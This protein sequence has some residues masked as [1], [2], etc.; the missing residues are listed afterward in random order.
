MESYIKQLIEDLKAAQNLSVPP[1]RH[2]DSEEMPLTSMEHFSGLEKMCFPPVEKLS[3]TQLQDLVDAIIALLEENK[4][5]V[6]VPARLLIELT[7]QKLL[8]KWTD[9]IDYVNSGLHG[10]DFCPENM[11]D[12]DLHE[13]CDWCFEVGADTIPVY[14]GI[15][16]DNGNKIDILDIP[17]PD[18]CLSCESFLDDDWEENV[19]C[20][21]T[22][23]EKREEGEEF[24][25][26]AW[27]RKT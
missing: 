2:D 23:A 7:Y 16:D 21:L 27:R 10:L 12:C 14:N 17:V 26:Y 3:H 18:L 9:E 11:D 8:E 19:L 13:W 24:V 25:C 4:Y 15:Y 20:N 22:R 5:V 6:N 1:L